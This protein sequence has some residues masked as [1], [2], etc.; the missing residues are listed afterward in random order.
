MMHQYHLGSNEEERD[1][2]LVVS[3]VFYQTQPRQCGSGT[4]NSINM[5]NN[6]YEQRSMMSTHPSV[7]DDDNVIMPPK[8]AAAPMDYYNP[9]FINY[10]HMGHN[11]ESSQL[12]PN[13][14]MQ[15]DHSS[16]FI[17]LAMDANKTA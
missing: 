12:I 7:Q 9:T 15:G 14:V 8:N 3:K 17:R 2:E 1:G 10:D 11:M 6:P 16:S 5:K 4:N 13:L